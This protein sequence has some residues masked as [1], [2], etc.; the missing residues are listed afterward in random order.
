MNDDGSAPPNAM[1]AIDS[2]LV[3]VFLSVTVFAVE[4]APTAVVANVIVAG[5]RLTTGAVPVPF[6]DTVCGDPDA[7]SVTALVP[8]KVPAEVGVK[9]AVKVQLAAAVSVAP[10]VFDPRV[11]EDA[12]VPHTAIEPIAK[13]AVPVFFSVSVCGDALEPTAVA[14]YVS[15]VGLKVATVVALPRAVASTV[16]LASVVALQPAGLDV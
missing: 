10:Q 8:V 3:P 15:V 6:N 16:K 4:V 1:E 13:V 14:A 12:L 7:S 5:V 9:V 11:N 2:A